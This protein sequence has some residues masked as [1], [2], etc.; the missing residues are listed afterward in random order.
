MTVLL[1]VLRLGLAVA[2]LGLSLTACVN[3]A[4]SGSNGRGSGMCG[5]TQSF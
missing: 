3:C 5:L 4:A 2:L 1:N